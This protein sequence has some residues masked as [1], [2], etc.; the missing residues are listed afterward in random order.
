MVKTGVVRDDNKKCGEGKLSAGGWCGC[1]IG[2]ELGYE[3]VG[4]VMGLF[5]Q[6]LLS[7]LFWII[8]KCFKI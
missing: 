8:L 7:Y 2:W 5:F 6:I 4:V 1:Q 3:D